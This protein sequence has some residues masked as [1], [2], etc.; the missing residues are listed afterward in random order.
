M[1]EL[2]VKLR[3]VEPD[4]LD[5]LYRL[6]NDPDVWR[7]SWGEAPVSRQMLWEYITNYTADVYRD[8]QLRFVIEAG[9]QAA[10]TI[11][12][13]DFD[14]RNSRAM[15]G[16]AVDKESQHHGI[17]HKAV[18]Q[19]VDYCRMALHLHQ[20]AVLV[21]RDNEASMRLFLDSGFTTS[22]CLRSWLRRGTS[23]VDVMV[24]QRFL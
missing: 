2:N 6:E 13:S 7:V 22:G 23:Y 16:I 11:D 12:I 15:L 20:L 4:D 17:A 8:R 21:P 19:V 9:G 14:P 1:E 3:A 24:L 10:G 18:E 5:T